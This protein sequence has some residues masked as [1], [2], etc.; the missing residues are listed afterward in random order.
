MVINIDLKDIQIKTKKNVTVEKEKSIDS[1]AKM[2]TNKITKF[3]MN[4][5]L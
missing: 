4:P 5:F 2:K 1:K 3:M